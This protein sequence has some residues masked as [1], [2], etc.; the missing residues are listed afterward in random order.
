[1][2][3]YFC[4]GC[5]ESIPLTDIQAG[6]VTTVKGK[7]FCRS[8]I[9]PGGSASAAPA[10]AQRGAAGPVMATVLL[11]L[12]AYVAWRDLPAQLG[13]PGDGEVRAEL[14]GGAERR[15][16]DLLAADLA[17]LRMALDELD[18]KATFQRGDVDGLRATT[19]DLQ[20]GLESLRE[21]IDGLQRGQAETGQLI[22]QLN[23]QDNR[24]RTLAS[25]IDT[26]ADML[27]DHETLLALRGAEA[28]PA[29]AQAAAPAVDTTLQAELDSIRR[30]LL[31]A[32]AGQRFAA[33]DRVAKGRHKQ[34]AADL[35]PALQDEDPFVRQLAMQVLGD[36]GAVEAMPALLDV[37]ED[38]NPII[39]KSAAETLVRLTGYDPGYDPR[40]SEAERKKA[41]KKWRDWVGG[42]R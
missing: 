12:V 14:E 32:D 18:R 38:P 2:K 22:E 19:A 41:V 10:V 21:S 42:G 11:L 26:L 1:M 17:Q 39:R 33:V 37:L 40:G 16:A 7:L 5:N 6:Q 25:R 20:R 29:A 9:P 24:M 30:Q 23:L 27:A 3:I 4:D 34:L 13:T 35:V 8:C 28:A 36:F 15:V 31:D